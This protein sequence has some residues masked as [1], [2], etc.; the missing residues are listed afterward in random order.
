MPIRIA[1]TIFKIL[2]SLTIWIGTV[3]AAHP[4][5]APIDPPVRLAP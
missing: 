4:G 1:R 5:L 2:L 3:P